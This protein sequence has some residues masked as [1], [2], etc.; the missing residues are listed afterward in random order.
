MAHFA[1]I[2]EDNIVLQIIVVANKEITNQDGLESEQ[3]GIQFCQQ[4]F[5]ENT[6][7]VQTSYNNKFRANYATIGGKYDSDRDVFI[8]QSPFPSWVLNTTFYQWEAPVPKPED[9]KKHYW[10][11]EEL[12]WIEFAT[13]E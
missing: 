9:G 10:S 2:N 4:L 12:K 6:R 3:L 5:G 13:V 11:E 1:Q 7:W 8:P